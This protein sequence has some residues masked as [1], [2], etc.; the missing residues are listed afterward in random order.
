MTIKLIDIVEHILNIVVLYVILRGLIYKPVRTFMLKRQQR[1][2]KE[3]EDAKGQMDNALQMKSQYETFLQSAETEAQNMI[4]E[5]VQR[6]D[7]SAKEILDKAQL[8]AKDIVAQG[9]EQVAQ[10]QQ[11]A[12]NAMQNDVVELAVGLASKIM[13]REISADDNRKIIDQYFSE[14]S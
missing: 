2:Q 6:A 10:E 3:R 1:L 5:G 9:R 13:Q 11:E 12:I 8:E 7:K 14:V 4:H